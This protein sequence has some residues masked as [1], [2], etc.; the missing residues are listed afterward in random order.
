MLD[1]GK[2]GQEAAYTVAV[3]ALPFSLPR[4]D[5]VQP[6]I[7]SYLAEKE[8]KVVR[9]APQSGTMTSRRNNSVK[10]LGS[11]EYACQATKRISTLL[12]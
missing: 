5:P 8:A 11:F 2:C 3:N 6:Q 12:F 4:H 9:E 7:Y 10:V 1:A